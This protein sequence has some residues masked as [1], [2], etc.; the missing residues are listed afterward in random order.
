MTD[1]TAV[2]CGYIKSVEQLCE[3]II[4]NILPKLGLDLYYPAIQRVT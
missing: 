1:F 2:V 3:S 4:F